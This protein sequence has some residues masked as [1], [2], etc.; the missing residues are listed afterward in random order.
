MTVTVSN[1]LR[2]DTQEITEEEKSKI[3]EQQDIQDMNKYIKEKQDEVNKAQEELIT[4]LKLQNMFPDLTYSKSRW[5]TIRFSSSMV[6]SIADKCYTHHTCGCCDDAPLLVRAYAEIDGF[7]V[8]A[9]PDSVCIGEK[10]NYVVGGDRL[11]DDWVDKV[12]AVYP[13]PNVVETIKEEFKH[14]TG[15]SRDYDYDDDY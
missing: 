3:K 15:K 1:S 10:D 12:K 5:G 2:K 8:Y 14:C 6:N 7:E 13:H 4:L 9:K 11:D